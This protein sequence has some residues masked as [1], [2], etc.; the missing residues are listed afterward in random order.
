MSFDLEILFLRFCSKEITPSGQAL[1]VWRWSLLFN[2]FVTTKKGTAETGETAQRLETT[3]RSFAGHQSGSQHHT[4]QTT[5]DRD[6]SSKITCAHVHIPHRY[7]Q[8][9]KRERVGTS[10][11]ASWLIDRGIV[12]SHIADTALVTR[13]GG[14]THPLLEVFTYTRSGMVAS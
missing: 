4:G 13:Q 3:Y 5:T 1:R 2:V 7:T 10:Q 8:F 11:S 12:L 14:Q 6:P 9:K